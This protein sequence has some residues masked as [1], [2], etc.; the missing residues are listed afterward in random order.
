MVGETQLEP[1][2]WPV[3]SGSSCPDHTV[4]T[5][6]HDACLAGSAA[7]RQQGRDLAIPYAGAARHGVGETGDEAK[8]DGTCDAPRCTDR[9]ARLMQGCC[10]VLQAGGLALPL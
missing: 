9:A 3:S 4:S 2:G 10:K 7:G 5:G 6:T 1:G 8:Q